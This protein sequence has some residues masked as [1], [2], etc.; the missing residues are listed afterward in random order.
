MVFILIIVTILAVALV[1]SIV[2]VYDLVSYKYLIRI[3]PVIGTISLVLGV[4]LFA[5]KKGKQIM[6][7]SVFFVL[8]LYL[9]NV[10]S[11]AFIN[12]Q[13]QNT[14]ANG[15]RIANAVESYYEVN[16]RYPKDLDEL[17]PR[18]I[19]SIPKIKTTYD[20]GDFVYF[21]TEGGKSYFLGFENYCFD[22]KSWI[23]EE[24]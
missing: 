10:I 21:L 19:G 5:L 6:I 1:N 7:I 4:I 3:L 18:Y 17:M 22:G 9:S 14:F 2:K 8:A 24:K 15:T 13:R 23:E 12:N 20:E 16:N 11:A